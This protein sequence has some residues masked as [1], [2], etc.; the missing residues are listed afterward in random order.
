MLLTSGTR[1]G[2]YDILAPIGAGGMGEVYRARDTKLSRV[3]A[4]KVLSQEFARQP[5]RLVRFEREA[6]AVASLNHPNIAAIHSFER[7]EGVPFL[8]LEYVPGETLHAPASIGDAIAIARQI[9]DALEAAHDQGIVHRDLKPANIKLTPEG[10]VKIL[11]FG[12]SKA[13]A[14]TSAAVDVSGS[15]TVSID[16]T[17][18]GVVM[19][20]AAYMSPEQSRGRPVDNRTDV[21]AFGCVL[22]ELLTGRAVFRGETL[23]DTLV[24]ILTREP[25]WQALPAE[26]PDNVRRLLRRCL[27]K[28]PDRRLHHIADARLELEEAGEPGLSEQRSPRTRRFA[29]W[30]AAIMTVIAAAVSV[31]QFRERPPEQRA[32][33]LSVLPPDKS[34]FNS[35][36]M[37]PDG[38]VLAF[39]ATDARGET[40]LWVRPL[41]SDAAQPLA[42][43]KGAIQPF[44]SPD[45]RSLGFFADGKLKKIDVAGGPPQTLCEAPEPVGAAW[46]SDGVIILAAAFQSPLRRVM[47]TGGTSEVVTSL[48]RSQREAGH[49]S[50]RFL[51]GGRRFLYLSRAW[52]PG[53]EEHTVT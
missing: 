23:E 51:P 20:T 10:K 43:T 15:P 40:Q 2:S 41:H 1:L 33:S 34:I 13:L 39:T 7:W 53:Q 8:V 52:A 17:E 6:R 11:D 47:A 28:D 37:S 4:I 48:D 19:G 49:G 27:Q 32:V 21:W 24:A 42:G 45:A 36:A 18:T 25:D 46:N 16:T 3:V 38:T 14:N 22:F 35:L 50:P 29:P 26:T 9:C 44:W 5:E 12:L 31:M 30:I